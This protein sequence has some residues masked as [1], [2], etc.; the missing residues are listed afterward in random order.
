MEQETD[1]QIGVTFAVMW[2][3]LRYDVVKRELS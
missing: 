2:A 1:R 3:L